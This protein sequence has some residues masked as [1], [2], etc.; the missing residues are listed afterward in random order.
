MI[1]LTIDSD[2]TSIERDSVNQ[3]EKRIQLIRENNPEHVEV[4]K[5]DE[6]IY[7]TFIHKSPEMK[8]ITSDIFLN[9]LS[10]IDFQEVEKDIDIQ[11]IDGKGLVPLSFSRQS[12]DEHLLDIPAHLQAGIY[13][14]DV[15]TP[16]YD[17]TY[18]QVKESLFLVQRCAIALLENTTNVAYALTPS[19]GHHASMNQYGGYCFL[20]N[21]VYGALLLQSPARKRVIILDIDYHYGDGTQQ[22]CTGFYYKTFSNNI[23]AISIH[24]NP[25]YD[26]PKHSGYEGGSMFL[27]FENITF[28]PKCDI[29]QYLS[30]LEIAISKISEHP[31]PDYVVLALG[32]DILMDDLDANMNGGTTIKPEDFKLIAEF[33]SSEL[34]KMN[35][36]IKVLITQEG[37]YNLELIPVASKAFVDNFK[38]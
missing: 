38:I 16:I 37:G 26:Y 23:S 24:I 2:V 32:Y 1:I 28:E 19:P 20:N 33:I 8:L 4:I 9:F 22:L 21:A 10:S 5:F 30:K 27:S 11:T 25:L 7:D 13:A 15:S 34:K 35:E 14:K 36:N 17:Y 3:P 29:Q 12:I 31:T 18:Q 6:D